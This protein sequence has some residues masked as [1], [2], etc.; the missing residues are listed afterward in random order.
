MPL[1]FA[2]ANFISGSSVPSRCTCSSH[3]GMPAMKSRESLMGFPSFS[4]LSRYAA[5]TADASRTRARSFEVES[6]SRSRSLVEH[7][8]FGKPGSTFPDHALAV[9]PSR[10]IALGQRVECHQAL[11]QRL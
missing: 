1:R 2:N 7:D 6:T 10:R 4:L 5:Q 8:L 11:E 9:D 3:L